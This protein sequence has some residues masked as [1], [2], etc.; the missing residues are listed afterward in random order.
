[1]INR[2]QRRLDRAEALLDAMAVCETPDDFAMVLVNTVFKQEHLGFAYVFD[3]DGTT[4]LRR[5][6]GF[7]DAATSRLAERVSIWENIG[8]AQSYRENAIVR[9]EDAQTYRENYNI[10]FLSSSGQGVICSPINIFGKTAGGFSLVFRDALSLQEIDD[11]EIRL[12]QLCAAH[13]LRDWRARSLVDPPVNLYTPSL[14]ARQMTIV[15][16]LREGVSLREIGVQ[17]SVSHATVKSEVQKVYR[18]LGVHKKRDAISVGER[19]GLFSR[20]ATVER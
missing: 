6:G 14:T 11:A 8:V 19:I 17:L 1:M 10:A 15:K 12:V 5:L 3:N 7:G 4:E 20:T 9:I 18:A 16:E 13:L 2:L